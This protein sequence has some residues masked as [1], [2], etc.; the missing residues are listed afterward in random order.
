[1]LIGIDGNEANILNRVGV[2]Q[3]AYHLIQKLWENDS[4]NEYIVY[5]KDQPLPDLPKEKSNWHYRVFGPKKLWTKFS[6]PLHLN[7]QK[8]KLD[9]FFSP[10]H[11]SPSFCPFPTVPTIHD[12]GYLQFQDQ[13]TKKDLYQL[14]N[15]TKSS[16]EKAKHII[17]VSEFSKKELQ[18]IYKVPETKITTAYNGVDTP[19]IIDN[20]TTQKTLK[21]FKIENPYFLYLGTLKP[22]KNIPFLI[23][24]FAEF[25]KNNQDFLLVI[26]G[27]KGWLFDEIFRTVQNEKLENKVIFT[28]YINETEKWVLYK[29][30]QVTVL[31]SVYEGFG[32]PAIESM[33]AGTPVI[34]SDIEPFREVVSSAGLFIDPKSTKDLVQKMELL[35]SQK[36]RNELSQKGLIQAKKFS[37]NN[38]AESVLQA[39]AKIN[40]RLGN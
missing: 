17:T 1:M 7:A 30:A 25:T 8:E 16:I 31:P 40:K 4:E 15:W 26:A 18:N 14:I 29:N 19:P 32:I 2:G 6:L 27:K 24:S 21:K 28:D 35:C 39:F 33:I 11:Y 13:F 9:L 34:A 3:Y 22:N 23:K 38:T 37:W 36:L 5:L 20:E 10:S 12:L